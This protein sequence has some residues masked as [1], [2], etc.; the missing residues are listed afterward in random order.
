MSESADRHTEC[1]AAV[2]EGSRGDDHLTRPCA[3]RNAR[4]MTDEVAAIV[5]RP[6][7]DAHGDDRQ[8][9]ARPTAAGAAS[10][11]VASV[12]SPVAGTH[13]GRAAHLL[14]GQHGPLIGSASCQRRR[15]RSPMVKTM[16]VP[17][18]VEHAPLRAG[19]S[20]VGRRRDPGRAAYRVPS[21]TA[22]DATHRSC[23]R[24]SGPGGIRWRSRPRRRARR[25]PECR[26]R[27]RYRGIHRRRP[28]PAPPAACMRGSWFDHPPPLPRARP[29]A[30]VRLLDLRPDI[31]DGPACGGAG[32][33]G[34]IGLECGRDAPVAR[35]RRLP[36]L[37]LHRCAA[38]RQHVVGHGEVDRTLGI[39]ISIRSP[40]STRP[41]HGEARR[42]W[43]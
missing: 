29:R 19:S 7:E 36:A 20:G 5:A 17:L 24:R 37:R 28:A 33:H 18:A 11:R 39:E 35:L 41:M 9:R 4:A 26:L 42:R 1:A 12:P 30:S 34:G 43:L 2:L 6:G 13:C 8:P 27:W 16:L 38:L 10:R 22:R 23:P 21:P 31:A 32:G 40:S 25:R 14:D 15:V 3:G